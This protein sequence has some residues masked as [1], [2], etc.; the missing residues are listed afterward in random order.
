MT[1]AEMYRLLLALAIGAVIGAEREYRSKSAGLRTM[2]MVSVSSCLFTMLSIKIGVENPDR[3]AAN[4]LTGLGFLGA[5]VIF[6]DENRIS[7]ITTATT[8]WMTAA[9]GMAVGAGYEVLSL[10]SAVIVMM[11]LAILIY[12]QEQIEDLNQARHYRI[13]CF[14]KQETLDKYEELFKTY[15]LKVI[16]NTQH[17]NQ[18]RISG[19]WILIGSAANHQRLTEYL[20]NDPDIQELNF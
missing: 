7:G 19:R 1:D 15:Q 12:V 5:G 6:K 3:L 2:I 11:V 20:L 9:L 17:K 14:Y 8:I 10:F 16:R 4:I 13:V 18:N